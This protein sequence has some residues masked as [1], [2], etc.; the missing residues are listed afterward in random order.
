MTISFVDISVW[1]L[2]YL[3]RE[4]K[5]TVLNS[6]KGFWRSLPQRSHSFLDPN[7]KTWLPT[8]WYPFPLHSQGW[9]PCKQQS[10]ILTVMSA[11]D[12]GC[13]I[14]LMFS[15]FWSCFNETQD[16]VKTNTIQMNHVFANHSEEDEIYPLTVKE[17]VEAQST[18]LNAMLFWIN[19]NGVH[20]MVSPLSSAPR[21]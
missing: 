6:P 21:A 9:M 5:F 4:M 12:K 1:W 14:W 15:K 17:I 16:T 20:N 2:Q 10:D 3:V 8:H 11:T 18:S 19:Y 13:Q 7:L